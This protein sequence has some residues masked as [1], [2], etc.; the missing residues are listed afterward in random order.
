MHIPPDPSL[1]MLILVFFHAQSFAITALILCLCVW[2][3]S[4]AVKNLI[5]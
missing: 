3:L 4:K 5:P 1:T 2:I